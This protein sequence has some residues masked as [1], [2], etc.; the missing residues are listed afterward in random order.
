M[1]VLCDGFDYLARCLHSI[2]LRIALQTLLPSRIDQAG[3][4]IRLQ[5]FGGFLFHLFFC[6]GEGMVKIQC[7]PRMALVKFTLDDHRMVDRIYAGLGEIAPRLCLPV[8]EKRLDVVHRIEVDG[9]AVDQIAVAEVQQ[10]RIE[11]SFDQ[12]FADIRAGRD[13][14]QTYSLRR[15]EPGCS[16]MALVGAALHKPFD[17]ARHDAELVLQNAARPQRSRL[18]VFR[19]ADTLA[20]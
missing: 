6:L 9:A 8:G 16:A 10:R 2:G 5:C 18:L 11:L 3:V 12:H 13:L 4:E 7:K 15:L 1:H 20:F 14:R 19:H 17:I